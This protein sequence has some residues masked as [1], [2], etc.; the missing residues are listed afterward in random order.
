MSASEAKDR[1]RVD[2][3]GCGRDW[4]VGLAEPRV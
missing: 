4:P 1:R 3:V 2:P